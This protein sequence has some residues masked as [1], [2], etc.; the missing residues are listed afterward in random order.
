MATRTINGAIWQKQGEDL[1]KLMPETLASNVHCEYREDKLSVQGALDT[2]SGELQTL[3]TLS[4]DALVF[5]GVV[6]SVDDLPRPA[7]GYKVGDTYKVNTAGTYKGIVTEPGDAL[8]VVDTKGADSDWVVLQANIDGAVTGPK[9]AIDGRIVVFDGTTGKVIKDSGVAITTVVDTLADHGTR[10]ASLEGRADAI[11]AKNTEQDGRLDDAEDRLDA[12]EAKNTEQDGRLDD[13]ED[14]NTEQDGRLAALEAKDVAH[15]GRLD[16]LEGRMDTAEG[17]I[18]ALE[19]RATALEDRATALEGRAD[20]LE[21]RADAIE[22]KNEEQDGRLDDLEDALDATKW[23]AYSATEA[24][25]A[26]AAAPLQNY[27]MVICGEMGSFTA[28]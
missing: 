20:A 15:E 27:G 8:I 2:I 17:D 23:I 14:K 24:G 25:V 10:I 7:D 22:A 19:D 26:T 6:N 28:A 3:E 4:T 11:E 13:V 9:N 18:D 16:A 1:V 12:V 5:R 21:D